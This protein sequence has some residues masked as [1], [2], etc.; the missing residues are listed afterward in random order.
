MSTIAYT[1]SESSIRP[2]G[3]GKVQT[4]LNLGDHISRLFGRIARF[5]DRREEGGQHTTEE[6]LQIHPSG[7]GADFF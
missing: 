3:S 1:K 5:R 4:A 7:T 2:G 6:K